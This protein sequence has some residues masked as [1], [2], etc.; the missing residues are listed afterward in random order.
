MQGIDPKVIEGRTTAIIAKVKAHISQ[1]VPVPAELPDQ[2]GLGAAG[3]AHGDSVML[4]VDEILMSIPEEAMDADAK[5]KLRCKLEE[6]K[7]AKKQ[8]SG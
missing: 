8:R 7:L 6:E 3:P 4:T 5:S 1:T 2:A